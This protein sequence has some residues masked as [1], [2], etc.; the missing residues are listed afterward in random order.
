MNSTTR[1]ILA[2][3]AAAVA[4]LMAPDV[5]HILPLWAQVTA[6]VLSAALAAV[7][8]PPQFVKVN[9]AQAVQPVTGDTIVRRE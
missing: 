7:M 3:V 1:T 4:G 2:L 9:D 8:V 6:G 5:F